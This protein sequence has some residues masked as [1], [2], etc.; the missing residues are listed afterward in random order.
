M[1]PVDPAS[2]VQPPAVDAGVTSWDSGTEE[3]GKGEK[4]TR[5]E[6]STDEREALGNGGKFDA[7]GKDET[8]GLFEKVDDNGEAYPEEAIAAY[9]VSVVVTTS[10]GH[11]P[12]TS[13]TSPRAWKSSSW[14]EGYILAG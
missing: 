4:T 6:R 11:A 8:G 9:T 2:S 7:E 5:E 10:L 14:V 1:L 13:S 12:P 3:F